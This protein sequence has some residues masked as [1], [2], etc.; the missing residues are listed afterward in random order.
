MK[1]PDQR[2]FESD[3]AK[4][5]FRLGQVEG[6][7]RLLKTAWPYAFVAVTAKDGREFV[8]RLNCSG[9]PQAP[10]TGGPWDMERDQVLAFA[11][12]PRGNGGR[13]SAVFRTDWKNGT[14]LYLPCDGES[15]KGH[16][17]WRQEM[18]SKV[19]RPTDGIVQYLE[20]VHELLHCR[21]YAA[22]VV[23]EA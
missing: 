13:V 11:E 18:P 5:P 20:Q 2:A 22:S 10:P 9:H 12:W 23:A 3:V 6:R 4:A 7:W 21:D 17:H 15:I 14:A 16:D 1:G 19:W 8:L